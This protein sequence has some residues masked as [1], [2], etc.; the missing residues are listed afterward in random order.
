MKKSLTLLEILIVIFALGILAVI[1]VPAYINL[2]KDAIAAAETGTVDALNSGI[3]IYGTESQVRTRQPVY[4]AALDSATN[5]PA[6]SSNPFFD[7]VTTPVV[8]GWNKYTPF[9]YQGPTKNFYVYDQANG[10]VTLYAPSSTVTP[11]QPAIFLPSASANPYDTNIWAPS[12]PG[13][14]SPWSGTPISFSVDFQNAGTYTFDLAAIN[15]ANHP[16]FSQLYGWGSRSDWHLPAGYNQFNM[17]V[18]I[19]GAAVSPS[20]FSIAASDTQTNTGTFSADVSAGTHTVSL[21]W[22]ND[23][24]DPD[25]NG[26]ANIQIQNLAITKS[27]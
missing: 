15:N 20:S 27:N 25:H 17:Q 24:Y 3:R 22:T 26:D 1:A 16:Y 9:L 12:G 19:D 10:R 14:Y 11:N 21:V 13:L 18:L 2:K 5:A 23:S 4:P 8:F 6:K 7:A